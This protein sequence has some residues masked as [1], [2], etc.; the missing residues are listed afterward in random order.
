MISS[1]RKTVSLGKSMRL[2]DWR[3]MNS[4]TVKYEVVLKEELIQD[5]TENIL[6]Q[7]FLKAASELQNKDEIDW[8]SSM[9]II[10]RTEQV[11]PET[12]QTEEDLVKIRA[13]RPIA[14]LASIVNESATLQ[15]LVDLGV[16]LH[17]WEVRGHMGMAVKLDFTEHVAPK[18]RFLADLGVHH[19]KI[20]IVLSSCPEILETPKEDLVARVAYLASKKFSKTDIAVLIANCPTW[21]KF[22]VKGIDG[23]LGF[24]QKTFKLTGDQVREVAI[25][26]PRLVLWNNLLKGVREKMFAF[27]EEMGFSKQEIKSILLQDPGSFMIKSNPAL[28]DQFDLLHNQI[29]IPHSIL[30]KFPS[31]LRRSVYTS[32]G[33][34]KFLTHLHKAQYNPNLPGYVSPAMLAEGTDEEFCEKV[35]KCDLLLFQKFL[36]TI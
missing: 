8:E 26:C 25:R 24:L 11:L 17:K 33:R 4:S 32:E 31:V 21:L 35:A 14:S 16:N 36:R 3:R 2:G 34:H 18:I 13:S 12:K 29:G 22:S 6:D 28:L 9:D 20:G 1:L 30:V 27:Y 5:K 10:K 19:H 7:I 23:R 15:R